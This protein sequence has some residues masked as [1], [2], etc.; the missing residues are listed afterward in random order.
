MRSLELAI[1]YLAGDRLQGTAAERLAMTTSTE[2]G[3]DTLWTISNPVIKY[4]TTTNEITNTDGG[5]TG[6]TTANARAYIQMKDSGG[7]TITAGETWCLQAQWT[8]I[9]NS[10]GWNGNV[11]P[12]GLSRDTTGADDESTGTGGFVGAYGDTNWNMYW[13]D[14]GSESAAGYITGGESSNGGTTVYMTMIRTSGGDAVQC[15]YYS[16]SGRSS[17]LTG[18]NDFPSGVGVFGTVYSNVIPSGGLD[19]MTYIMCAN[20]DSSTAHGWKVRDIKFW[21]NQL[22]DSGDPD[23]E[24]VYD[25]SLTYNYP[26]LPNG[27]IFEQSDDGKH[28]MWDGTSAWNEIT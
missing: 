25:Y 20:G 12:I 27:T 22:D 7:S 28:Y 1:K 5:Q 14:E 19:G 26:N 11:R 6:G 10:S 18:G 23:W 16:N 21:N 15:R 3:A 2:S 9:S 4:N 13:R 24:N 17:L 8:F